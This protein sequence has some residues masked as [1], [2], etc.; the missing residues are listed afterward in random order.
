[1]TP[2]LSRWS[3]RLVRAYHLRCAR[4]DARLRGIVV[5]VGVWVCACR[6]VSLDR[7]AFH[8]HLGEVHA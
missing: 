7:L 3:R 2:L 1:M 4:E 6:H 5:P 8:R